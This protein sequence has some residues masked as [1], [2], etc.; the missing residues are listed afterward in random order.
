MYLWNKRTTTIDEDDLVASL[1]RGDREATGILYDN[2][3]SALYGL[4]FRLVGEDSVAEDLLQEA[5]TKIWQNFP[6]YDST[7]GRLFT[8]MARL[9]RNLTID[10]LKSKDYRNRRKNQEIDSIVHLVDRETSV[11]SPTDSI[12]LGELVGTLRPE[13]QIIVDLIYF[14]GL[15][16]TEAAEE[17]AIPLG[18]VKTRLRAAISEMRKHFLM[19]GE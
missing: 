5:F 3:A 13:Q 7:K 17:L 6:S 15:T 1:R 4:I 19:D 2:Y 14:R 10:A 8:W 11:E 12:G 9:V 16:H 18:T